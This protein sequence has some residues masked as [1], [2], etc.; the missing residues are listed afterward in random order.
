MAAIERMSLRM[1]HIVRCFRSGNR[2]P[3]INARLSVRTGSAGKT[4]GRGDGGE[5]KERQVGNGW[6]DVGARTE[7]VREISYHQYRQPSRSTLTEFPTFRESR[8]IG[9]KFQSGKSFNQRRQRIP[10]RR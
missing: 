7:C 9:L 5:M 1:D 4:I 3:S 8:L 6:K 2:R 10:Y